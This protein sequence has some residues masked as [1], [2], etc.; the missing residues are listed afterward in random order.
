MKSGRQ[1]ESDAGVIQYAEEA[2][3][4]ANKDSVLIWNWNKP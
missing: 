4:D 2:D 1:G 3:D